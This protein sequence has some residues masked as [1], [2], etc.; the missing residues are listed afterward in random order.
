[1][2]RHVKCER[3]LRNKQE[4]EAEIRIQ[5]SQLP[6]KEAIFQRLGATRFY[7]VV[8]NMTLFAVW[9]R[10]VQFVLR[11]PDHIIKCG[12]SEVFKK[13]EILFAFQRK[14]ERE[15]VEAVVIHQEEK[16]FSESNV[17]IRHKEAVA[18]RKNLDKS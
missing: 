10:C 15:I 3:H 17:A 18:G 1:M 11:Q 13:S 2:L 5:Q 16:A 6:I 4:L 7:N 12:C 14:T 9:A 8:R